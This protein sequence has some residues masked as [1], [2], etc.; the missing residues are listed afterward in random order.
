MWVASEGMDITVTPEWAAL[1]A[2]PVP[3][4]LRQLFATAPA[5]SER[6]LTQATDLRMYWS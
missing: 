6:S 4:P 2:V 1:Q 3:E 5:R